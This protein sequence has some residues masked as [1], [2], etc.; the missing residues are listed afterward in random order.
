WTDWRN[1][2]SGSK[3]G[4][5]RHEIG[6]GVRA[7]WRGDGNAKSSRG[8]SHRMDD[9]PV[10]CCGKRRQGAAD[11]CKSWM[12]SIYKGK[13]D[14]MECGSYRGIK[15]LEHAMKVFERVT[16]ARVRDRVKID[17][18]QFG[19][20]PGKGTPDAI[21]IV[22]QLQEKYL[23]KTKDLWMAFIDLEKA[24]DRVRREVLWWE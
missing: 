23:A 20:S 16:E 24:F 10:Q 17:N 5:G 11:W 6:E 2:V 22:R 3:S 15:L 19:F 7:I 13:G 1:N 21:F 14:A 9:G 4:F 12:I 18:M 8:N